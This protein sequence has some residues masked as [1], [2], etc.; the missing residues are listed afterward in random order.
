MYYFN[1][2]VIVKILAT[3]LL[4]E[5]VAML[6]PLFAAIYYGEV[7][8]GSAFFF[9]ALCC[10][11]FGLTIYKNLSEFT[12]NLRSR[13]G[14]FIALTTWLAVCLVGALPYYFSECGYSFIDSFFESVA[15]WT[16]TGAHVVDIRAIPKSILLWK[17][18]NNWLGGMGILVLTVSIFPKLGISGQKILEAEVLGPTLE[19]FQARM[20]DS[21]K[22]SYKIY[23]I[24]TVLELCLLLPS[25]I[26]PFDALVNTLSSISTAGIMNIRGVVEMNLTVYVKIILTIFSIVGSVN[27]VIFFFISTRQW[28]KIFGNT[29]LKVYILL[30][31]VGSFFMGFVLYF[32][33]TYDDPFTALDD[34][35]TQTV[36]FGST[37]GFVVTNINTWP[38]SC[39]IILLF[40]CMVGGCGYSTAGGLKVIRFIVFFKIILRGIY[41]R[42]H[43]RAVRP[44]MLDNAPISSRNASSITVFVLLY[45]AIIIT[46]AIALSLDNLDL[47][48]TLSAAV[49]TFTNNG[50]GF[51][52]IAFGDYSD[53][54][55]FGKFISSMLM[56]AGRLEMYAMIIIFSRS[57]WNPE[58]AK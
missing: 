32:T 11:A 17:A 51:G 28:K 36:S 18:V 43:P 24:L 38:T 37:S 52:L 8:T 22:I 19:K 48:T 50:C 41:K 2:R 9:I 12:L 44:I 31:L 45:F 4:F 6:I 5:G 15:G 40:L 30:L 55:S 56:I 10:I 14:F 34:A 57:F 20:G 16:T 29:E 27:F 53:F 42:I 7:S 3:I 13:D 46:G 33:G 39:K 1:H 58:R 25:G 26:H 23:V 47:E 49:A 21:A 35:L 54:S